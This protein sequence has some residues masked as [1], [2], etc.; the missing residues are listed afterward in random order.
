MPAEGTDHVPPTSVRPIILAE[1][2]TRWPFVEVDCCNEC[3]SLLGAHMPWT[4][5]G[6]KEL[7]K[8][9]L[10]RKYRKYLAIPDWSAEE[11]AEHPPRGLLGTFIHEGIM[12]KLATLAR[13]KW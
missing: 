10:R 5:N 11:L 3:N 6:R 4:V 1:G 7:I 12:V 13:L 2:S 8:Q 9:K